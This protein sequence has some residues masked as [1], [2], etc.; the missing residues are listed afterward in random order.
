MIG[1]YNDQMWIKLFIVLVGL[2]VWGMK[3]IK[4]FGDFSDYSLKD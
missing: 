1:F 2:W 4:I 3:I